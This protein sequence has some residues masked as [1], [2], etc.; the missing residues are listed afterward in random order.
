VNGAARLAMLAVNVAAIAR[1]CRDALCLVA[2]LAAASFSAGALAQPEVRLAPTEAQSCL[3]PAEA[4]RVRPVYPEGELRMKTSY[5]AHAELVFDG[6]DARPSVEFTNGNSMPA[7]EDAVRDYARQLRVPCMKPGAPPVRLRQDFAFEP[8][9]GRK[10]AWTAVGDEA[11]VHRR[12]L[13]KCSVSPKGEGSRIRYPSSALSRGLQ[14]I[15]VTRLRFDA[16]DAPPALEVVDDASSGAFVQAI[17]PFVEQMRV[18]CLQHESVEVYAFFDFRIDNVASTRL[19]LKDFDLKTYLGVVKPAGGV[20]FD[21]Q[22]M[23]C[24]FD[25]RLTFRQPFEP[26]TIAELEADDPSRHAFLDWLASLQLNID[27]RRAKDLHG[28]SSTLHVPCVKLD[29]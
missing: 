21:T 25:V 2:G 10:V 11:D 20:Y 27:A 18:P 23:H 12:E 9:D 7:F 22:T 8:N 24:P 26:N 19:V 4:D 14:G 5:T 16:A 6:P 3:F 28:Q 15:V 29:L 17:R 1:R 13:L